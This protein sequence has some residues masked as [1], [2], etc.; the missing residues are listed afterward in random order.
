LKRGNCSECR[1]QQG[2]RKKNREKGEEKGRGGHGASE[3]EEREKGKMG[4]KHQIQQL[5]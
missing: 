1:E 2:T 5:W 3:E 4:R